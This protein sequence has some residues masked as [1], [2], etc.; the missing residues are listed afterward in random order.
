MKKPEHNLF[1][2]KQIRRELRN[3][4]TSS[5]AR[6]WSVLK[7]RMLKGRKFRRQHS[8][9]GYVVDFFCYSENL[10][11]EIDGSSHDDI[12][13][14]NHDVERDEKLLEYGFKILRFKAIEIKDQLDRVIKEIEASFK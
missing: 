2:L 9:D 11:V 5:E 3:N 7:D 4:L 10:I 6:L 1:H 8:I 14:Q 13:S 12:G